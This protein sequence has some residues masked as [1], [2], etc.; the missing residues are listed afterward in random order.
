M[1]FALFLLDY[2]RMI[3]MGYLVTS[4]DLT[5]YL[6]MSNDVDYEMYENYL[7]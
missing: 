5:R 1:G 6:V 2:N 7:M 3:V 4:H